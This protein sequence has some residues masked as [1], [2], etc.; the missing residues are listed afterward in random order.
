MILY[1]L[2]ITYQKKAW[3]EFQQVNMSPPAPSTLKMEIGIHTE[4]K[5]EG[6]R[7]RNTDISL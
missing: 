4:N 3:I 6:C 2:V 7:H 5:K 1:N